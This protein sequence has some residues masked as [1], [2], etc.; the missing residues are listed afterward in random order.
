VFTVQG[1]REEPTRRVVRGLEDGGLLRGG[2]SLPTV[3]E[4]MASLPSG[5]AGA[6][7]CGDPAQNFENVYGRSR[8]DDRKT[9]GGG[10][11]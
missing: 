9:L 5:K 4:I 10:E 2:P 8:A 1:L 6:A 11:R 7:V 3:R